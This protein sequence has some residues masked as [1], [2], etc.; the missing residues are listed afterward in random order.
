MYA[1]ELFNIAGTPTT[2]STHH[3]TALTWSGQGRLPGRIAGCG[4]RS[5]GPHT[6]LLQ[7]G[8]SV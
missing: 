8:G 5:C 7:G 6:E 3:P 4:V 2:P 1:R